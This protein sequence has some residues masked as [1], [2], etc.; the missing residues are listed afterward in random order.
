MLLKILLGLTSF[1][2]HSDL[3]PDNARQLWRKSYYMM[4][5]G[6]IEYRHN[7]N[8][9]TVSE[10]DDDLRQSLQSLATTSIPLVENRVKYFKNFVEE[11]KDNLDPL[12]QS[13][14]KWH[15]KHLEKCEASL[16]MYRRMN[17]LPGNEKVIVPR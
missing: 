6:E 17:N 15:R 4:R 14:V 9:R 2:L 5:K 7:N 10:I 11:N 13:D 3:L 16:K 1:L 12:V 8:L